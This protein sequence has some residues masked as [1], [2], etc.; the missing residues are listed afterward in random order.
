MTKPLRDGPDPEVPG[1]HPA[2]QARSRLL[3]DRFV[4]AGRMALRTTRLDDLSIPVLA[5]A[6]ASSVGGFYSRFETKE[7]FFEFLRA[8]MLEAHKRLFDDR[9]AD[10]R[11]TNRGRGDVSEELVDAMLAIFSGPWRGVLRE[12]YACMTDS[13]AAWAPMRA[14]GQMVR[15]RVLALYRTHMPGDDKLEE[16]VSMAVQLLYSA[17]N[18]E[19]MN[20][21]LTFKIEDPKFRTYLVAMVDAIVSGEAPGLRPASPQ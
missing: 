17:L 10:D 18:N 11:L 1:V 4:K 8:K 7:A 2:G 20:P 15:D 16:R 13:P 21:N 12:A 14:R 5:E 19:M 3:Q 6:A 9:L